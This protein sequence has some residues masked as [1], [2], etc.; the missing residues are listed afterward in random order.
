[1]ESCV[2]LNRNVTHCDKDHFSL[3]L[4]VSKKISS[5]YINMYPW[6]KIYVYKK[7]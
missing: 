5:K 2:F 1:M 3:V 4:S 6:G 7:I